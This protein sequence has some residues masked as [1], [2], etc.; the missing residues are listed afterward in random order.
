MFKLVIPFHLAAY[1]FLVET[2]Q[3]KAFYYLVKD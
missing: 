2:E 3:T 1:D